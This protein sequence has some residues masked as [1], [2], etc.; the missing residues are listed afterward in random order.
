MV[1][2]FNIGDVVQLKSG[3]INMTVKQIINVYDHPHYYCIWSE[4]NTI[5]ENIISRDKD[6]IYTKEN[7]AFPEAILSKVGA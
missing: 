1:A 7:G 3:G 2:K 6:K 4:N 5:K